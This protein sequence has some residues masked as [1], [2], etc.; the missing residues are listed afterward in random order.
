M[1]R[2]KTIA[3]S[4]SHRLFDLWLRW[5]TSMVEHSLTALYG[6]VSAPWNDPLVL[7]ES[8]RQKQKGNPRR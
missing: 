1:G 6:W 3:N 5:W 8:I 2:F 7:Y 4:A